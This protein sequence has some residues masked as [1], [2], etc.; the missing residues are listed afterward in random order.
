MDVLS[1]NVASLLRAAPGTERQV[2][3]RRRPPGY[4]RRPGARRADQR[5]GP[6]VANRPERARACPPEHRRRRILQPLPDGCRCTHPGRDRGGGAAVDRHRFRP[7]R[8]LRR[9][10]RTRC[11]STITTSSTWPNL[12]ARRSRLAEP[13][14]P[15]C[16]EDCA[17][18]CPTCGIDLNNVT[19]HSHTE[20]AIDPRLAGSGRVARIT[21]RT[22]QGEERHGSSQAP[23]LARATGRAPRAPRADAAAAGG[24][25]ALPP[26]RSRRTT[27][28]PTAAGTTA[29]RPST[30]APRPSRRAAS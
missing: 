7:A 24:V 22:R 15:L 14:T 1:Y 26:A 12:C 6:P 18:L 2:R 19:D 10:S 21:E 28:A 17:G 9:T 29:A 25:P 23:R 27:R 4:R 8:Q 11:R 20:D 30:S 16:R 13:I 3:G 5:R